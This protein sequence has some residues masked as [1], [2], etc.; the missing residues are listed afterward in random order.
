MADPGIPLDEIDGKAWSSTVERWNKHKPRMRREIALACRADGHD[1]VW[2]PVG[3]F[4]RRCCAY[5]GEAGR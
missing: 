5:F 2:C 3:R 4:C 1:V